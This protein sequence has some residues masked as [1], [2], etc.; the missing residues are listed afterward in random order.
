MSM[1]SLPRLLDIGDVADWLHLPRRTVKGM[2]RRREIPAVE[3]PGGSVV[4]DAEDLAG[5][6]EQ[7]KTAGEQTQ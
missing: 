6:I 2:A 5:W 7:R 3:L 1:V 4:F